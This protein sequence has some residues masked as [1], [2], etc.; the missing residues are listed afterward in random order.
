MALDRYNRSAKL[1]NVP[2]ITDV[3]SRQALQASQS[4]QQRL[5]NI[6]EFALG[7]LKDKALQEGQLYGVKNAPTIEQITRAV[8]QDQDVNE[9]FAE[10]G[11]VFGDA[12]RKVQAQLFRQDSYA[13][14]ASQIDTIAKNVDN[15]GVITLPEVENIASEIQA[16]IN[17]TVEILKDIDVTQAVKFNAEANVLGNTLFTTLNTKALELELNAKKEQ[18][19]QSELSYTDNFIMTLA[20]E[21]GDVVTTKIKM[22]PARQNLEANYGILP[23]GLVK[24]EQIDAL[25]K[26]AM[27]GAAGKILSSNPVYYENFNQTYNQLITNNPPAELAFIKGLPRA[28]RLKIANA[29]KTE[30]KDLIAIQKASLDKTNL[31]DKIEANRLANKYLD[32]KDPKILEQIKS[33]S[34]RNPNAFNYKDLKS[35][36]ENKETWKLDNEEK[37][38][39]SVIRFVEQINNGDFASYNEMATAAKENNFDDKLINQ[40]FAKTLESKRIR[41]EENMIDKAVNTIVSPAAK[42]KIKAKVRS[43]LENEVDNIEEQNIINNN[44]STK[45][46]VIEQASDRVNKKRVN[47]KLNSALELL[48]TS[49]MSYGLSDI[50]NEIPQDSQ[51]RYIIDTTSP[52]II[53]ILNSVKDKKGDSAFNNIKSIFQSIQNQYEQMDEM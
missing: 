39:P 32:T 36:V 9:L 8:Q 26:K 35:L 53:T 2:N 6:S 33:L 18:V 42:P 52:E 27:I 1:V 37:Y 23:N 21:K 4:L 20:A 3:G 11:S 48:T 38:K 22:A 40:Y 15:K 34:N 49:L 24:I 13:T 17:S 10:E 28:D 46:E 25:E 14:F 44:E 45:Q 29:A 16:N 50:E 31:A 47:K 41:I 43:E 30:N 19:E 51:G 7:K 12:A 5:D